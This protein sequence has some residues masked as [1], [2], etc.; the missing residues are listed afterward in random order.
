V[1]HPQINRSDDLKR[2]LADG[3]E[4]EIIGAHLV[5]RSVPYVNAAREV[6]R[7]VLAIVPNTDGEATVRPRDHVVKFAGEFPCNEQGQ[8]LEKLRH[9]EGKD[10]ITE[11]LVTNYTFSNKP[12]HGYD[13]YHQLV[14]VYIANISGPAA[15]LD[16]TATAR[17]WQVLE[18]NDPDSVFLY[19]DSASSRAGINAVS[20]KL[21][22]IG[23]IVIAGVGGSGSYVLDYVAKT[24]VKTIDIYDKDRMGTHNA[25]RAP[26]AASL[27]QLKPVPYKVDYYAD[28]YSKMRRG[29][30]PHPYHLD[31]TN[32]SELEGADFV[33]ICMDKG[34][35]KKA[36]IEKLEQ[37]GIPFVDVGMGLE[38]SEGDCL[39]G[40]V[41]TTTSTKDKRDHVRQN[42]R[43]SFE[44][45]GNDIYPNIQI[46]ELNAMNAAFAV[47]KWKKLFGFYADQFR[48]HFSAYTIDCNAMVNEDKT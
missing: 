47:V 24:P 31:A 6:K 17:T 27:V 39:R 33:F 20:R 30:V 34:K 22:K 48:E 28:I 8:P 3:Y 1:S 37:L 26:G 36:I 13:D 35:P 10:A 18:N 5:V 4:I 43:I 7:G 45:E 25:F 9:G 2:L 11:D 44:G 42:H 16:P 14:T 41:R 21:E 40:I 46:A 32:L 23:R 15:V 29:V 19:P 12:P 38:L